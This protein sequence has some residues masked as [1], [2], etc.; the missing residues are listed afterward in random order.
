[1]NRITLGFGPHLTLDLYGCDK[2]KLGDSTF[3]YTLL[4]DIAVPAQIGMTEIAPPQVISYSK[5]GGL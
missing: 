1:M 2:N 4:L 3:V 5:K